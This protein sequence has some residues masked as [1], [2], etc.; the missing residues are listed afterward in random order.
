VQT[1]IDDEQF[2]KHKR[3]PSGEARSG[4]TVGVGKRGSATG[5]DRHRRRGEHT[6]TT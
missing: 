6:Q 1:S 3:R 2:G 5:A 4:S